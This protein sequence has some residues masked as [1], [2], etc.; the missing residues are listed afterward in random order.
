MSVPGLPGQHVGGVGGAGNASGMSEQE[1]TIVKTVRQI[2]NAESSSLFTERATSIL[3][4]T[5]M[6]IRSDRYV[7]ASC[8]GELS[9]E[10][11]H[12][13]W[14][15]VSIWRCVWPLYVECT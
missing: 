12:L 7:D 10:D 13:W 1:Q 9:G 4:G 3:K 6:S 14:Y 5:F 11:C 2:H 15:G 8:Y